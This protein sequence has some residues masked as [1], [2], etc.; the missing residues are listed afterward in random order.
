[1][2]FLRITLPSENW[3]CHPKRLAALTLKCCLIILPASCCWCNHCYNVLWGERSSLHFQWKCMLCTWITSKLC[4]SKNHHQFYDDGNVSQCVFWGRIT[5]RHNIYEA[6]DSRVAKNKKI[7]KSCHIFGIFRHWYWKAGWWRQIF[8]KCRTL[9]KWNIVWCLRLY[10]HV[11]GFLVKAIMSKL[12]KP[13]ERIS[14]CALCC[15]A[16]D[17]K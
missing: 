11:V 14:I 5:R 8:F 16:P 2:L 12:N 7:G 3:I 6:V 15:Q 9:N 10:Q 1:M 17:S 13:D 4:V